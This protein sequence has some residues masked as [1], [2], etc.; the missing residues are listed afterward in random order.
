MARRAGRSSWALALAFLV[1]FQLSVVPRASCGIRFDVSAY[2]KCIGEEIQEGTLVV[3]SYTVVSASHG[4]E[5]QETQRQGTPQILFSLNG[6]VVIA[7]LHTRRHSPWSEGPPVGTI[8]C[9]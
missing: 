7:C 9:S 3:G 2:S 1:T 5:A 6:H 4:D 8:G